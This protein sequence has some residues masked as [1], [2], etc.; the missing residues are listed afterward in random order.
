MSELIDARRALE[1]LIDVVDG[2]ENYVYEK[3]PVGPDASEKCVY[4]HDGQPSCLVGQ[5]LFRAGWTV[6]E[7]AALDPK[8][9]SDTLQPY[10]G[11]SADEIPGYFPDR[12]THVAGQ[13]LAGAQGA[14]DTGSPWGVALEAA[15]DEFRGFEGDDNA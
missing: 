15:R 2:N 7:I 13:I 14:Q 10:G 5:V 12:M 4:A 3:L 1:L 9:D 8:W 6:E 11:Y